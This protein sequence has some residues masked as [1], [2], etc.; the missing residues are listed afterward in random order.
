MSRLSARD[1]QGLRRV[2]L[3]LLREWDPI[4]DV[5]ADEYDSYAGQVFGKLKR[6]AS[7]DEIA[8][9]LNHVESDLMGLP[10]TERARAHNRRVALRAIEIAQ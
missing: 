10:L 7:V 2:E 9:Y 8:E 4:G 3:L 1:K 5:P 6:G